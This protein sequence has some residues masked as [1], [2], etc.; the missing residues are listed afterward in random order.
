MEI[1]SEAKGR[2]DRPASGERLISDFQRM[3]GRLKK[4]LGVDRLTGV[5]L[6]GMDLRGAEL[7]GVVLCR[8]CCV[9]RGVVSG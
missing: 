7:A 8:I 4:A 1:I 5:D 2:F 6:I 3:A 9:E